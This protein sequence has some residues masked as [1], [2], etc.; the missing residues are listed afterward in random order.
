MGAIRSVRISIEN[1]GGIRKGRDET[2]NA[3]IHFRSLCN[4]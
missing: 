1:V 4:E 3:T 2:S